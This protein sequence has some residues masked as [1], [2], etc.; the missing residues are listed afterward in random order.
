VVSHTTLAVTSMGPVYASC[1][2][3]EIALSGGWTI[4][5]DP[6]NNVFRSQRA[7]GGN[8]AV[9]VKHASS[10]TV[11]VYAECLASASGAS[12]AERVA[13]VSIPDG[14]YEFGTAI[15]SCNAGE[16]LV[17]GGFASQDYA[18]I[19]ETFT[20]SPGKWKA[21]AWNHGSSSAL[22]NAYAEC[23]TFGGAHSNHIQ[24]QV[25]TP[26]ARDATGSAAP[27]AC[28]GGAYV[29]GGGYSYYGE[30]LVYAMSAV[31]SGGSASWAISL[32]N[33]GDFQLLYGH[34][35]CLGFS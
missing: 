2:P 28:P 32:R 11:S 15:A 34:V 33:N 8:W 20:D 13:Q 22:L 27:P 31:G 5:A 29:S 35:M 6:G 7:G 18:E 9:Y 23:L 10:M 17:G 3:G 4:P 16:A 24:T 21:D 12:I 25:G 19:R 14:I 30:G 26:I 1:P